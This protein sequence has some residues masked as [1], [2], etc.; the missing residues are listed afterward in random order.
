MWEINE[1]QEICSENFNNPSPDNT[2]RKFS[3]E[4][5]FICPPKSTKVTN[6]DSNLICVLNEFSH[7]VR[8]FSLK[9]GK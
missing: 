1:K 7:R 3:R 2:F 6:L 8:D 4:Y 9:L 5:F